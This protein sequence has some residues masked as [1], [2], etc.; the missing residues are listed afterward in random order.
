[1]E[2]AAGMAAVVV[3]VVEEDT[4]D[5]LVVE[6]AAVVHFLEEVHDQLRTILQVGLFKEDPLAIRLP[7][8]GMDGM[9][10]DTTDI[11]P[12]VLEAGM[13]RGMAMAHLLELSGVG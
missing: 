4:L 2:G 1:M 10:G 9:V 12:T 7:V 8:Q 5:S 3:M 13:H 6:L 11:V